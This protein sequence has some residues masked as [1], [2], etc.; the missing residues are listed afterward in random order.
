MLPIYIEDGRRIIDTKGSN[1]DNNLIGFTPNLIDTDSK[2]IPESIVGEW[3]LHHVC[4]QLDRRQY[5]CLKVGR[6]RMR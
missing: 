3:I 6:R 1:T 5:W 2:W 4:D